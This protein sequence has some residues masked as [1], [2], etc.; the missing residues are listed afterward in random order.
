MAVALS[1][2]TFDPVLPYCLYPT[3]GSPGPLKALQP[4]TLL[5]RPSSGGSVSISLSV[6]LSLL[7]LSPS[8]LIHSLRLILC[9]SFS[10]P[11]NENPRLSAP[12]G[13]SPGPHCPCADQRCGSRTPCPAQPRRAPAA[14]LSRSWEESW[15]WAP[16]I[17]KRKC[18]ELA[19]GAWATG[20]ALRFQV[21]RVQ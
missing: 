16:L 9:L 17:L 2:L 4:E 8:S 19:A 6:G 1:G 7:S 13:V 18:K 3:S 14:G 5:C 15:L 12:S 21:K 20:R 10:S 11:L